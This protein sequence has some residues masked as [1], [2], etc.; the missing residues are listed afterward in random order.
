MERQIG[1]DKSANK[2]KNK[3][4]NENQIGEHESKHIGLYKS[5]KS[6]SEHSVR[7]IQSCKIQVEHLNCKIK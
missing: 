6:N 7:T 4:R 2:N 3:N 1:K 5:N